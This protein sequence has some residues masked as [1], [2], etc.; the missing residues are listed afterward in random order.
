M[1]R[2]GYYKAWRWLIYSIISFFALAGLFSVGVYIASQPII[3]KQYEYIN[4]NLVIPSSND[5]IVEGGRQARIHG[6]Y[7]SCHGSGAG[8]KIFSDNLLGITIPAPNL[9]RLANDYSVGEFE[10]SVR[11][12]IKKDGTAVNF[13]PSPMYY[14]LN[15]KQLAQIIAFLRRLPDEDKRF[16]DP[17]FG[18]LYR[19]SLLQGDERIIPDEVT[20]VPFIGGL[21]LSDPLSHGKY[22]AMTTCSQCHGAGLHGRADWGQPPSLVVTTVYSFDAFRHLLITGEAIGGRDV[23]AMRTASKK[24]FSNFTKEEIE[25]LYLY[26]TSDEF[27][28]ELE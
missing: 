5:D 22:L 9:T 2:E 21:D 6:C 20:K 23:G 3:D 17:S 12:G 7:N 25:H 15:D 19:W 27:L 8:G 16:A 13:M 24:R 28:S 10:R 11:Q 1:T 14:N 4:I 26:L 18:L